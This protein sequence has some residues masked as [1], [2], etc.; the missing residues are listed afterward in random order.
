MI[1][2]NTKPCRKNACILWHPNFVPTL[3]ALVKKM[4]ESAEEKQERLVGMGTIFGLRS[5]SFMIWK[6]R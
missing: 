5:K 6:S 4:A 1:R 3:P 2:Q